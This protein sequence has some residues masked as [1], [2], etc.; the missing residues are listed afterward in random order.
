M[1]FL[2]YFSVNEAMT[3]SKNG[4]KIIENIPKSRILT[5]TDAP[6]NSK[7]DIV[8][9]LTYLRMT[10]QDI[11]NNFMELICKIK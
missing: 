7:T 5:E 11:K 3:L 8:K 1:F 4:Q 10:E 2:Y 6:Y 9:V